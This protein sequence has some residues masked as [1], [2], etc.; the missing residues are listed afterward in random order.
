MK[1]KLTIRM[2][3]GVSH[4][5]FNVDD[6]GAKT[7]YD[8]ISR[9]S[10]VYGSS[11]NVKHNIKLE[12]MD[13]LEIE[14]P[15]TIFNKSLPKPNEIDQEK[16]KQAGVS[17]EIDLENPVLSIFGAWDSSPNTEKYTR[18]A[19]K[20]SFLVSEFRPIHTLLSSINKTCGVNVGDYNSIVTFSDNNKT[21]Y[22]PE[23]LAEKNSRYTLESA[24]KLFD[25]TRALNFFQE[26]DT[27]NGIYYYDV[28][29]DLDTFGKIKLNDIK[30]TDNELENLL[31]NGWEIQTIKREKYLSKSKEYNERL[32]KEFIKS[33]F[34]WDF[35]SNNSVHGSL[36]E[37]L[38]I[39][40]AVND[41]AT[42][43]QC[44]MAKLTNDNVAELVIRDNE[45]GVYSY[46]TTLLSK[47]YLTEQ[48]NI[49]TDVNAHK[50]AQEKM[51]EVAK[52]F[53]K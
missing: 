29:I 26:N 23:E 50:L 1:N 13:N 49:A 3:F 16:E 20:S 53:L 44:T 37:L 46:N 4:Q 38:R 15:K 48:N 18:V 47:Y 17:T 22:T 33:L 14:S 27:T 12:F 39:S 9:R 7:H 8:P 25:N 41:A 28:T 52:P 5:V 36:K 6:K 10:Y 11:N 34:N 35:T 24:K 43:Q 21:Y 32:L 31:S 45:E 42:W 51:L 19:L 30:P 40:F 2:L